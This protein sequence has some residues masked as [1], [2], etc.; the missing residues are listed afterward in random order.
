MVELMLA[1][2]SGFLS[3][4][5]LHTQAALVRDKPGLERR[6]SGFDA[7]MRAV[8]AMERKVE[9]MPKTR[10]LIT[11]PNVKRRIVHLCYFSDVTNPT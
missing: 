9:P 3:K 8:Q 7:L 6:P 2:S 4:R 1:H 11:N 10:Q 5:G